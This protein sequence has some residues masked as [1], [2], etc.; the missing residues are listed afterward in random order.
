MMPRHH[1]YDKTYKN[2]YLTA[3]LGTAPAGKLMKGE[4][5]TYVG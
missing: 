4:R 1:I 2:G 3:N 5:P